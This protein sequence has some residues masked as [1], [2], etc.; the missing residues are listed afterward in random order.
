MGYDCTVGGNVIDD[1]V[2][3]IPGDT[4]SGSGVAIEGGY[5]NTVTANLL[6]NNYGPTIYLTAAGTLPYGSPG[7]VATT[8]ASGSNSAALPAGTINVGSTAG[9]AGSG[10]FTVLS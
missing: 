6:R 4:N 10:T 3:R 5:R 1:N 7:Q 8:V 9:F 2:Q